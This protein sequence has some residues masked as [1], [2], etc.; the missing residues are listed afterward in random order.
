[1]FGLNKEKNSIDTN[2]QKIEEVLER[3]VEDIFVKEHLREAL[4]SGKQLRVKLGIDPT[5]PAIHLGRAIPLRKL[6]AFQDLGH[7]IVLIIGDFTAKI[8]DPSDKLEKRPMLTDEQ[9]KENLKDYLKQIGM[10]IDL[11]K[12][13]IR[14]NSE[15]LDG[16]SL[17]ELGKLLECFTIQQMSKRRNFQERMEQD[18]DVFVSEFMYPAFQGYDSVKVS[19]DVEIGGFDQLFNLKAGRTVQKR[20]GQKEQDIMVL[21]MLLGTDG[22]KMSSSWG[23]TISLLDTK[24]DMFGKVMAIKDELIIPY[25]TLCTDMSLKEISDLEIQIKSGA[26]PKDIKIKLAHEVVRIYHGEKKAKEAE[27]NFENTFAKGGVPEDIVEASVS[28]GIP[29]VDVLLSE[30]IIESKSEFRR[31][32]SE[33]AITNTETNEKISD[34]EAKATDGTYKIGKRRFIKIKIL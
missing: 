30:K 22:R 15:W 21:S 29:L 20:F 8:A 26:N 6:K 19:A 17:I 2:P 27:E 5:G 23:N 1:M 31:L 11:S 28:S 9:I 18:Q 14:Y 25:Y 10:I 34:S 33:G 13:E 24:E 3:G 32:I 4:L 7:K 16:M 12:A